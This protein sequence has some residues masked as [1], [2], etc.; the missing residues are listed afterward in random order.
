MGKLL[1]KK[2]GRPDGRCRIA[3]GNKNHDAAL[4]LVTLLWLGIVSKLP[5]HSLCTTFVLV[6]NF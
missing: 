3:A 2:Q 5:L 4:L 1:W 6:I